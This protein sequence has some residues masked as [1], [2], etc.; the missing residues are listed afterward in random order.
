M[1][2]SRRSGRSQ[3]DALVAATQWRWSLPSA[4]RSPPPPRET[5]ADGRNARIR[6]FPAAADPSLASDA[7]SWGRCPRS[8]SRKTKRRELVP[9]AIV[10]TLLGPAHVR[11]LASYPSA[12]SLSA[13]LR[14]RHWKPPCLS[15]QSIFHISSEGGRGG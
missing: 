4:R 1:H 11:L 5:A 9:T 12:Q 7:K 13:L 10:R 3:V 15:C 8:P 2:R 14:F 6:S